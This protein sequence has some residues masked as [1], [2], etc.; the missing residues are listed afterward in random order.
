[1]RP[2]H[3]VIGDMNFTLDVAAQLVPPSQNAAWGGVPGK[4]Y[5]V[6]SPL[7]SNSGSGLDF[8]IGMLVMERHYTVSGRS[9]LEGIDSLIMFGRCLT[10]TLNALGL[11]GRES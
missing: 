2:I 3:F 10:R 6:A 9:C 11:P 8:I 7:G 4:Q 5:G 1:M